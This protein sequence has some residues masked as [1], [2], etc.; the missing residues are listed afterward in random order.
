MIPSFDLEL[1]HPDNAA[2]FE[3]TS[4]EAWEK[5]ELCGRPKAVPGP[6]GTP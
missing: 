6:G 3:K 5:L 1:R 4:R 2:F